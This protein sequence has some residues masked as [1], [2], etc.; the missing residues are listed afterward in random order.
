MK[1]KLPKPIAPRYLA[2]RIVTTKFS[3]KPTISDE[4][5]TAMFRKIRCDCFIASRTGPYHSPK[6][7]RV[8]CRQVSSHIAPVRGS[9]DCHTAY[10]QLPVQKTMGQDSAQI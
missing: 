2:R 1:E 4:I 8:A 3:P 6:P 10:V 9:S 7:L 5:I